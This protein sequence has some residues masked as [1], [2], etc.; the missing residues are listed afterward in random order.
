MNEVVNLQMCKHVWARLTLCCTANLCIYA[1]F[2]SA[3]SEPQF[4][5][6]RFAKYARYLSLEII[7]SHQTARVSS[8]IILP[9]LDSLGFV[10]LVKCAA[11][12]YQTAV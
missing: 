2:F 6:L 12:R 11:D 10:M 3:Y 7:L 4:N 9:F 5:Y 1:Y 8:A